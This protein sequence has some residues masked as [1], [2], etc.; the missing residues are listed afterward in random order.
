MLTKHNRPQSAP[1]SASAGYT[2]RRGR[3]QNPQLARPDY[4]F[5]MKLPDGRTMVVAIPGR[6]TAEDRD[7]STLLLPEA[8][9]FLDRVQALVTPHKQTVTPGYITALREALHMTQSEF[10]EEVDVAKMTVS[11]WERGELRPAEDS[12]AK[13]EKLRAERLAKGVILPA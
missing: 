8:V 10:G 1:H 11:R 4:P 2:R 12:L 9:K 3:H 7:G 5:A 13:I 6:W